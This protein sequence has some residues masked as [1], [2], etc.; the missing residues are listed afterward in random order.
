MTPTNRNAIAVWTL[1]A[2]IDIDGFELGAPISSASLSAVSAAGVLHIFYA[3]VA[4][5][6]VHA[7][8]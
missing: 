5:H 1:G 6:L 7:W 8:Q 2:S 4:G 3:T